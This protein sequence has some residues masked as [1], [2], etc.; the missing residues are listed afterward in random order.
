MKKNKG[1]VAERNSTKLFIF[2]ELANHWALAAA[3][4]CGAIGQFM[5]LE[6]RNKISWPAG[7]YTFVLVLQKKP[8][9]AGRTETATA[10]SGATKRRKIQL[11][12]VDRPRHTLAVQP[13]VCPAAVV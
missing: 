1:K 9:H 6:M 5:P 2:Q 11:A 4:L 12:Q 10:R 13:G 7:N 8:T 3:D